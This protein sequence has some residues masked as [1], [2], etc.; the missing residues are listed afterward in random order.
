MLSRICTLLSCTLLIVITVGAQTPSLR[1]DAEQYLEFLRE[2]QA[3]LDFQL[4]EQEI[5]RAFYQRASARIAILRELVTAYGRSRTIERLPEFHVVTAEELDALIPN[6][7]KRVRQARARQL[8]DGRWR[9][10]KVALRGET[11]YVLER[12]DSAAQAGG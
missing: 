6:G 10:I 1:A 9:F 12:V 3:E 7:R 4:R 2:E 11:F 8:I 5:T